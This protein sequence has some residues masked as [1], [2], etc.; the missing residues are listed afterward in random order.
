MGGM[1]LVSD[2]REERRETWEKGKMRFVFWKSRKSQLFLRPRFW[3]E[4]SFFRF[5]LVFGKFWVKPRF[6]FQ[7][8]FSETIQTGPSANKFITTRKWVKAKGLRAC[9]DSTSENS[10]WENSFWRI[11]FLKNSFWWNASIWIKLFENYF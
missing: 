4:N 8:S 9:L 6:C 1:I 11:A 10:F 5:F 3:I 7:N 2:G